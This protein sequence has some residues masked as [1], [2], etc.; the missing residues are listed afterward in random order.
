MVNLNTY[1]NWF[2]NPPTS[3]MI[4]KSGWT[5]ER[6]IEALINKWNSLEDSLIVAFK[7]QMTSEEQHLF[8]KKQSSQAMALNLLILSGL[9]N[10]KML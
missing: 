4:I 5:I 9:F 2:P 7:K 8:I 10:A 1:I 3:L 6:M